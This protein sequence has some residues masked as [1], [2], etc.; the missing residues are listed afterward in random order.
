MIKYMRSQFTGSQNLGDCGL[1]VKKI[2]NSVL[3]YEKLATLTVL[4]PSELGVET[5]LLVNDTML[6]MFNKISR[7]S[8]KDY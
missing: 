4:F 5:F 8:F 1:A 6:V 3:H 2:V 7:D